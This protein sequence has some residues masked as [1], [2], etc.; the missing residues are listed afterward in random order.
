MHLVPL[1]SL[2]YP[3][4]CPLSPGGN[5]LRPALS[6]ER[7]SQIQ[8]SSGFLL[9]A[10]STLCPTCPPVSEG[11]EWCQ[12]VISNWALPGCK[13][14]DSSTG[15]CRAPQWLQH[16]VRTN[17]HR[18]QLVP[19]RGGRVCVCKRKQLQM[20]EQKFT[21]SEPSDN[22]KMR[23]LFRSKHPFILQVV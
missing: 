21:S 12:N 18:N 16:W 8:G 22:L 20:W 11:A 6:L 3:L 14:H 1:F 19:E 2:W 5:A 23:W 17:S 4:W 13:S 9:A 15:S 10:H 7:T